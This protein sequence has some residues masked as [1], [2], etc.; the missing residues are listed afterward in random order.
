MSAGAS[1]AS[2]RAAAAR[3]ASVSTRPA[4]PAQEGS[5]GGH[6]PARDE[7][8]ALKAV[9]S[10]RHEQAEL[11]GAKPIQLSERAC[12]LSQRS[13]PVT[14]PRGVL[15]TEIAGETLQLRAER[16]QRVGGLALPPV[17]RPSGETR[18][19]ATLEWPVRTRRVGDAPAGSAPAQV[20]VAI[21]PGAAGIRRRPQL[22]QEPQL[23]E[24]SLELGAEHAPLDPLE[25]AKRRLDGRPLPLGPEVRAKPRAEVAGASHVEHLLVPVAEEVDPR[26]LRRSRD[27]RALARQPARA[28]RREVGQLGDCACATLLRET[29]QREQDLCRRLCICECPVTR[30]RRRAEEVRER[31]EPDALDPAGEHSP[32]EPHGVDNRCGDSPPGQPLD[33]AVEEA[34][35]EPG[36]VR[37]EHRVACE[38]Q[39]TTHRKFDR[40]CTTQLARVDPGECGDRGRQRPA[41][42]DERLEPLLELEAA[43]TDRTD[44][45]DR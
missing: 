32:R 27:E 28:R 16:R 19:P 13:D 45:A 26:P 10:R 12:H 7:E 17:E 25:R 37:H 39:E 22:A 41:R 44:L 42:V 33:L 3:P 18:S 15:E 36:V 9:F 24:R 4:A 1:D 2:A 40:R 43:H 34:D 23:L 6:A 30:P 8:R 11:E 29:D 20:H 14:Q 38:L 21:G 5:R 31:R 35:V